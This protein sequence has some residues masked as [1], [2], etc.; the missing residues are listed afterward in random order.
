MSAMKRHKKE[1]LETKAEHTCDIC[2][3]D[4]SRKEH[5]KRHSQS[6]KAKNLKLFK[7]HRPS[8]YNENLS[9]EPSQ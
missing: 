6:C 5:L 4:F 7:I 9:T 8:N 2:Q 3:K 1:H